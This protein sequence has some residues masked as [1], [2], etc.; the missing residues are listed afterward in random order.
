MNAVR[1]G[2]AIEGYV[3]SH[4]GHIIGWTG[5]DYPSPIY[6]SGHSV[7]G[8]QTGS[9][10]KTYIEGRLAARQGDSGVTNCPCDGQGYVISS[11]SS[12]VFIEGRPA[13]RIYDNVD[14]HGVGNGRFV[15]S[16][17]KVHIG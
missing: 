12:K 2:D 3:G 17:T 9:A 4:N 10:S 16:S 5:G 7:Y 1:L 6:C 14:I 15:T 13:A 11:G 8:Q